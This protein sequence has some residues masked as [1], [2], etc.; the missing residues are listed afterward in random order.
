M[1]F[2]ALSILWA[3]R[4]ETHR[5]LGNKAVLHFPRAALLS[6]RLKGATKPADRRL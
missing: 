6:P 4:G 5:A 2:K 1:Q 3:D